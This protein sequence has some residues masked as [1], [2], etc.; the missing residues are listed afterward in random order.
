MLGPLVPEVEHETV[1]NPPLKVMLGQVSYPK[2]LRLAGVPEAVAS[3]QEEIGETF[4]YME[5]IQQFGVALEG[6]GNA[7]LAPAASNG[8]NV[9]RFKVKGD[10]WVLQLTSEH[11]TLEAGPGDYASYKAFSELFEM[12]IEAFI[13][14]FEPVEIGRQGLRYIDHLVE[15][16]PVVDWAEWIEP[17]LLGSILAK[18][19]SPTLQTAL[20]ESRF[21]E[22]GHELIFRHGI[23]DAGPEQERGFLLDLDSVHSE[24]VE[25]SWEN[26]KER[27]DESHD[28]LYRLFRWS[29]TDAAFDRFR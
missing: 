13:G 8:E 27:F 11:M 16:L 24:P 12:V 10:A 29:I 20:T 21:V 5:T 7:P 4:P 23:V 25:P 9:Y 22:G 26:V 19:F 14:V 3:F 6:A 28:L 2:N 17:V 18:E 15:D 1:S